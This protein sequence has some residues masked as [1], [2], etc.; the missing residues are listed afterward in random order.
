MRWLCVVLFSA[1]AM[2]FAYADELRMRDGTVIVGTYVGGTQK[3]VYFQHSAAG[4]DMYPLFMVESV[5]FNPA[6]NFVPGPSA[7]TS[8][9]TAPSPRL[10]QILA[11]RLKWAFALLLPPTSAAEL[12]HSAH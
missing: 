1:C 10:S 3:E 6:P 4:T 5:K 9:Q 11:A 7:K 12:A 8:P 2:N